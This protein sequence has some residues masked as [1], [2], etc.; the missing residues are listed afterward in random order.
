MSI[1]FETL[2]LA[3]RYTNSAVA[4]ALSGIT[5]FDFKFVESL[6]WAGE[7]GVIYCIP[8][9]TDP[10]LYDEY[11]YANGEFKQIPGLQLDLSPYVTK[12][13]LEKII[14]RLEVPKINGVPIVGDV[15]L[16]DLGLRSIFYDTTEKWNAQP[17]LIGEKGA[18]YIY[19]N[20]ATENKNG[21]I[22]NKANIK[23]GDGKTH[24]IDVP[25]VSS[26]MNQQIINE[27]KA[28]IIDQTGEQIK[29]TAIEKLDQEQRLVSSE[30]REK[31]DNKITSTLSTTDPENLVLS[32]G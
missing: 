15:A 12:E 22:I 32:F 27:I 5:Q 19:S 30:D 23:I 24:L 25:F 16:L 21:E 10:N 1:S 14:N 20:Y 9:Q 4:E 17:G 13:D 3:K 6:P 7:T 18:I 26:A 29:E 8:S 2:A 28:E 31:W 11:Y